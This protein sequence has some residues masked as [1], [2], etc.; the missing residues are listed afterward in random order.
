[1]LG[2]AAS[3]GQIGG[4]ARRFDREPILFTGIDRPV[5]DYEAVLGVSYQAPISPWWILQPDLQLIGI[6]AVALRGRV[7]RPRGSQ[8]DP[9]AILRPT[10]E[11]G[12]DPL[13]L[14]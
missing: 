2:V 6:P 1:M 11:A 9:P 7:L 4:A 8:K 12:S 14:C 10:N 13:P 3:Y 5:R